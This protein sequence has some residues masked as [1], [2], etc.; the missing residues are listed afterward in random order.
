M[1]RRTIL[2]FPLALRAQTEPALIVV[3]VSPPGNIRNALAAQIKHEYKFPLITA[4]ELRMRG[5]DPIEELKARLARKDAR[6]G[7]LLDGFPDTRAQAEALDTMLARQGLPQPVA[8]HLA[9]TDEAVKSWW[10]AVSDQALA[11]FRR[12]E[13]AM[14]DHYKDSRLFTVDATQPGATLW[15][16]VAT[17]L[18]AWR[19]G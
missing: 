4:S 12:L 6:H 14:L 11:D 10:P 2:L 16:E 7:L 3:L 19:K 9:A 17:R 18:A 8:I 13:Q 15:R 5:G 1:E